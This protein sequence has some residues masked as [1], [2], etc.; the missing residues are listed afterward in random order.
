LIEATRQVFAETG[1]HKAT[2]REICQRAGANIAAVNNFFSGKERL[3]AAAKDSLRSAIEKYPPSFGLPLT[4]LCPTDLRHAT[5]GLG[6]RRPQQAWFTVC[7]NR[8]QTDARNC[9]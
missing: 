9:T 7:P 6:G 1:F 3:Y 4:L 5:V 2:T 8:C